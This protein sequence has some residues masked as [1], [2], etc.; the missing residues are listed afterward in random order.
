MGK[1]K[2]EID[3]ELAIKAGRAFWGETEVNITDEFLGELTP[4]ERDML[5][6]KSHGICKL[7]EP[8][9]SEVKRVLS[10]LVIQQKKDEE[11]ERTNAAKYDQWRTQTISDM[12]ARK[13]RYATDDYFYWQRRIGDPYYVSDHVLALEDDRVTTLAHQ[14]IAK[15]VAEDLAY[16]KQKVEIALKKEEENKKFIGALDAWLIDHGSA[17]QIARRKDRLM[18]DD[19]ILTLKRDEIFKPIDDQLLGVDVNIGRK[20]AQ[21]TYRKFRK[22]TEDDMPNCDYDCNIDFDTIE[23]NITLTD[24]QYII[25]QKIKSFLPSAN[26]AVRCHVAKCDRDHESLS[27][28][29]V[30]V[31]VTFAGRQLSREYEIK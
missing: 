12:L 21:W 30:L 5:S 24:N 11:N 1:I 26:F 14:I 29:T 28:S 20:Y 2:V 16:E 27:I 23:D 25:V 19:E 6:K 18:S 7:S 31:T 3:R 22:L 13:D 9:L 15:K 8:T 10:D 17:I 4:E